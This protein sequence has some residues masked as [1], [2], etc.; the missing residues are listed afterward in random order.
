MSFSISRVMGIVGAVIVL[1]A[2]LILLPTILSSVL[3]AQATSGIDQFDGVEDLI[4]LIPLVAVV[5]GIAVA[6]LIA[7]TAARG[8]VRG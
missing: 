3:T 5:G 1:V 8:G 4:G 7:F 6:G 2:F